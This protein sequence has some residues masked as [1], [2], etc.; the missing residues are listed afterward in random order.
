[1]VKE[2]IQM[3]LTCVGGGE[4]GMVDITH[5][6]EDIALYAQMM[7]GTWGNGTED[8]EAIDTRNQFLMRL[9]L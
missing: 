8:K 1:M 6:E 9:L 4:K 7:Y 2:D 5:K 3:F